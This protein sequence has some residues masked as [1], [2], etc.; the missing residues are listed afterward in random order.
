MAFAG[1]IVRLY[2]ACGAAKL[3][4]MMEVVP[5]LLLLH[6]MQVA[7]AGIPLRWVKNF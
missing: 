7:L 6:D 1:Y 2:L 4:D 3:T 5:K